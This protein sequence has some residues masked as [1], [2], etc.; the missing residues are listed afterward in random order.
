LK[1]DNCGR[2]ID[3]LSQISCGGT[4][5][6][7]CLYI[8]TGVYTLA[9]VPNSASTGTGAKLHIGTGAILSKCWHRCQ[10]VHWLRCHHKQARALV[11]NYTLAPWHNGA[12]AFFGTLVPQAVPTPTLQD[13]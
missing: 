5:V 10:I 8:G 2:L 1:D 13:S 7:W 12:T 4:V 6:P 3:F 11:P 9:P